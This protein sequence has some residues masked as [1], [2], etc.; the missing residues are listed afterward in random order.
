M[1]NYNVIV[2]GSGP[3][4]YKAA[5]KAALSGLKVLIIEKDLIGGVCTNWGCIPTK[6][7]LNS[8]KL[9]HKSNCIESFGVEGKTLF[10]FDKANSWKNQVVEKMRQAVS[11]ILA[12]NKVDI[13]QGTAKIKNSKFITVDNETYSFDYL[14]IATGAFSIKPPIPGLTNNGFVYY[15]KDVLKMNKLPEKVIIIGGGII[16][17]EWGCFF[18]FLDISVT[19]IE[20]LDEVLPMA[21]KDI[22]SSYRKELKKITFNLSSK[23]IDIEE[24]KVSYL[25]ESV[26]Q[27]ETAD[28][29]LIAVGRSPN[30]EMCDNTEIAVKEQGIDVNEFMQT[31][32]P[33]IYAVGDVI[34]KSMLAHSAYK[35]AEVAVAH[36]LGT[37]KAINFTKIPWCIYTEPELAGVGIT[38]KQAKETGREI[39]KAKLPLLG[40]S[41]Y[42]VEYKDKRG[43][44]KIIADANT[45]VVIGFQMMGAFSTELI[46]LGSLILEGEF[47]IDDI[48]ETFFP[49]PTISE[50]FKDIC[51]QIRK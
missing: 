19:I 23:V 11:G 40:N 26:R 42:F 32:I 24:N 27:T 28:C 25:K 20:I 50:A 16:G 15:S 2:I 14:V 5:E 21:D 1:K 30:I 17:L 51:Y 4:G 29:I 31:N 33:N 49:H 41:R 47:R 39:I 9:Y 6:S 34:G 38:E 8:A 48:K 45:N 44:L 43:L 35:M 3:G 36:I 12:K 22:A 13:I 46:S 18:S 37:Q 7:L 10:N